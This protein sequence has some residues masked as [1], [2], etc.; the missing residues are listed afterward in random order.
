MFRSNQSH[1][2][3][4]TQL[5]ALLQTV[6]KRVGESLCALVED[7]DIDFLIVLETASKDKRKFVPAGP[8]LDFR[9]PKDALG[10]VIGGMRMCGYV[11]FAKVRAGQGAERKSDS[12]NRAA[13]T[14]Q[15]ASTE[16]SDQLEKR[17]E[18][19]LRENS[20]LEN[21]VSSA[22][23]QILSR[24]Q[25]IEELKKQ[26]SSLQARISALEDHQPQSD[27][28]IARHTELEAAEE[29][30][31]TRMNEYMEKEAELEQREENVF[32]L[33][34]K[35]HELQNQTKHSA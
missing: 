20:M 29:E 7:S 3:D 23:K 9:T 33:E 27:T 35:F 17:L 21:K 22:K 28:L 24:N 6:S 15:G 34:R 26:V 16:K 31:I 25:I 30:L 4:E 1:N 8:S 11:D 18:W 12:V 2:V 14:A 10:K 13:A 32:H 19:A 5:D